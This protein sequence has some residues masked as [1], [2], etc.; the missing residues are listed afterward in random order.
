MKNIYTVETYDGKFFTIDDINDFVFRNSELIGVK[1]VFRKRSCFEISENKNKDRFLDIGYDM[2]GNNNLVNCFYIISRNSK[3]YDPS[4]L[5]SKY[6]KERQHP[7]YYSVNTGSKNEIKK[8]KCS[9]WCGFAN[10]KNKRKGNLSEFK[11]L[12]GYAIEYSE[13]KFHKQGRFGDVKCRFITDY[14]YYDVQY[15]DNSWKK[16]TNVKKQWMRN[17]KRA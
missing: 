3:I 16:N 17:K 4:W 5:I 1:F 9:S 13:F 2:H 14:D 8:R 6:N 15:T 12:I 11:S 10:P 7:Y